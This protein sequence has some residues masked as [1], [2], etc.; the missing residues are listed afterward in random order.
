MHV[1]ACMEFFLLSQGSYQMFVSIQTPNNFEVDQV[2]FNWMLTPSLT[3]KPV[4]WTPIQ[5]GA[6]QS[7][8]V[9][10]EARARVFCGASD[11]GRGCTEM[12]YNPYTTPNNENLR[13]DADG[14]IICLEGY[15]NVTTNCRTREFTTKT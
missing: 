2:V 11:Y 1:H 10:L 7:N 8:V 3:Y 12:C 9:T 6:T 15:T 4:E 5:I 14:N 13:C